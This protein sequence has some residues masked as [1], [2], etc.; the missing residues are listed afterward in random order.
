MLYRTRTHSAIV[1]YGLYLYYSSRSFRLAARSLSSIKSKRSHVSI[2]KWV[3]K[4]DDCADRFRTDKRR[5]KEIFVDETLLQIDG[6]DYWLWIAYEPN[7]DI[8]LM[9]H[10]SRERTIF[11]CYQFFKQLRNRF[12]G[13]KPI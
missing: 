13:R 8:C 7:L 11:V 3:Q 12:G 4:Y 9:M 2:W 10:L 6:Y 1:R 5:V